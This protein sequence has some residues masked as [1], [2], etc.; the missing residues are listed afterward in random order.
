MVC[1]ELVLYL[2]KLVS[3]STRYDGL[4]TVKKGEVIAPFLLAVG[5]EVRVQLFKN[6]SEFY[7]LGLIS[8]LLES[9]L[10]KVTEDEA[11]DVGR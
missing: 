7:Q 3:E 6:I 9:E 1:N 2:S 10:R 5:G 8:F 11:C 4:S